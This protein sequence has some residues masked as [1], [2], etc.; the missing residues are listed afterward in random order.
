MLPLTIMGW[1]GSGRRHLASAC[2]CDVR[3]Y[4]TS[5][6]GNT[7]CARPGEDFGCYPGEDAM[8][9]RPPCGSIFRCN[10]DHHDVG[11]ELARQRGAFVRCGS[12]YFRPQPGQTRL[13][14]SC[15]SAQ[16]NRQQ[17]TKHFYESAPKRTCGEHATVDSSGGVSTAY[18]RLPQPQG[19]NP[20]VKCCRNKPTGRGG[21]NWNS[22]L[23]FTDRNHAAWPSACEALCDAHPSGRCRYF[24]HSFRFNSALAIGH[25]HV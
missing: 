6:F 14:C 13:N 17:V 21:I 20:A 9:I 5:G 15:A 12:R 11:P 10:V 2:L 24:S 8:W 22:T 19:A 1:Q 23:Q 7:A 16:P 3:F 25:C 18:R 4:Q